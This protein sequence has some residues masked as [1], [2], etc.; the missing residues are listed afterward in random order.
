MIGPTS[1]QLLVL[2]AINA[3]INKHGYPPTLREICEAIGIR[4]TNGVNDHLHA[5]ERK[6]YVLMPED[7]KCRTMKITP[8]GRA[9]LPPAPRPEAPPFA[10]EQAIEALDLSA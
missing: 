8:A 1:R 10:A 5:L 4:S 3:S 9:L 7:S 2:K 6:G